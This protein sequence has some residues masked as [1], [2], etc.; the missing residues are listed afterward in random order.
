M[1]V[2]EGRGDDEVALA[3]D[4]HPLEAFGGSKVNCKGRG[5][6]WGSLAKAE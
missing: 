4:L 6:A 1:A 2:G 3:A 5:L